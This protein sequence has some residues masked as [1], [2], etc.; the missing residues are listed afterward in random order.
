MEDLENSEE[1]MGRLEKSM[2]RWFKWRNYLLYQEDNVSYKIASEYLTKNDR[3]FGKMDQDEKHD[4]LLEK[5]KDPAFVK[6]N[7]KPT[8]QKE[9]LAARPEKALQY[10]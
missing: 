8:L 3:K 7:V 10:L 5:L 1:A 9:F 2:R 6:S 4:Y